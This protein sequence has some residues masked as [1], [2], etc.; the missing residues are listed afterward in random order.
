MRLAYGY[1]LAALLAAGSTTPANAQN[2]IPQEYNKTIKTAQAVGALGSDLFGEQTSFYSGATTFSATDV[3]LPGNNSLPVS[4]GRRFV[5]SSRYSDEQRA[6]LARDGGFADWEL[7]IPHLHGVFGAGHGWQVDGWD[8]A[9]KNSRCSVQA[10]AAEPPVIV[11]S[12]GSWNGSFGAA[13]Y[14]SGNSLYV[15]G[16]GDQPMLQRDPQN[17]Q[18]VP[19]SGLTYTWLT[20]DQW[21]FSC[22]PTTANG[23][24]GEAFL[25]HA[26]DG[27]RYW[28]NWIAT[29]PAPFLVKPYKGVIDAKQVEPTVAKDGGAMLRV[30]VDPNSSG[31]AREEVWILPTRIEDRFGN[32]VTYTYDAAHPIRLLSIAAS[33]G[34]QLA[35]TYDVNGHISTVSDGTR[36][37]QY[38]YGDGLTE[39]RLPD[40]SKW[41]INFSN[42]RTAVTLSTSDPDPQQCTV[43]ARAAQQANYTG[44]LTHPSGATGSFL[45]KSIGHNRSYVPKRCIRPS[46]DPSN[47]ADFAWWPLFFDTMGL[48]QKTVSG[49]GAPAVQWTY[50]YSP[51]TASWAENCVSVACTTTKTV[52]ATGSGDFRR[53]TFS[54]KYGESEGKLLKVETG[55]S[56]STILRTEITDYVTNPAGQLYPAL[57]GYNPF[58]R[59]DGTAQVLR[60]KWRSSTTQ[61]G[62]TFT[63]RVAAT[64]GSG[65][66][67]CFDQLARPTKVVKSSSP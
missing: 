37:W 67:Y 26:P 65:T 29:R 24:P 54:N 14:W 18:P 1:A 32:A 21:L 55:A 36:T 22:L 43:A 35:M 38:I 10:N 27:N 25:A 57:I 8:I 64:C 40:Q 59:S 30:P 52:E 39:V 15:P 19:T 6:L 31:L 2:T 16:S 7:D 66:T 28:F 51:G 63:W 58:G 53:Y 44:T 61:Q 41:L 9:S 42:L 60:P 20:A 5:V 13:E 45:F 4:I 3:S 62:R 12:W 50:A 47:R 23:V 49:P 33:D 48:T 56:S 17:P 46:S 11:G 34:R